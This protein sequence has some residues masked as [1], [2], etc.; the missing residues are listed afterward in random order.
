MPLIQAIE[1]K[2]KQD[3]SKY[4]YKVTILGVASKK[5]NCD[6][7]KQFVKLINKHLS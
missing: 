1:A 6:S 7:K 5:S 4:E 3:D 2:P